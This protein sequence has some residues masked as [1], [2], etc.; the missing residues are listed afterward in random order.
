LSESRQIQL[1]PRVS[2]HNFHFPFFD[3]A[4]FE[5]NHTDPQ[6]HSNTQLQTK[7]CRI[8]VYIIYNSLTQ[9][10]RRYKNKMHSR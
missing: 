2:R 10:T 1:W 5:K 7:F 4:V 3:N 8:Q 9:Q 6:L